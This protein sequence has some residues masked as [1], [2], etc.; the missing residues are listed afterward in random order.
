[1]V[2]IRHAC[3]EKGEHIGDPLLRDPICVNEYKLSDKGIQQAIQ[4]GKTFLA[5]VVPSEKSLRSPDCRTVDTAR[6]EF[7]TSQPVEFLSLLEALPQSQ[8]TINM[9]KSSQKIGP[10]RP[11]I[12]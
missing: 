12:T 3:V 5:K 1:M 6:I 4:T 10:I 7:K 9:E 11:L 2:L 8:A